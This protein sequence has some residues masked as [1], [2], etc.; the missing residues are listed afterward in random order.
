MVGGGTGPGGP[1]TKEG[2]ASGGQVVLPRL[3]E[4]VEKAGPVSAEV[5]LDLIRHFIREEEAKLVGQAKAGGSGLELAHRRAGLL[6]GVVVHLW[7]H[8][9]DQESKSRLVLGAVGGF[10]REE[11]SPASDVDLV[12]I[13]DGRKEKTEEEVVRQIL[14]VL[15]DIGL[16]VGHACRTVAETIERA[17]SEP[18]IKTALLD[19]R[20]L[21]GSPSLWQQFDSEFL[22]K[23]LSRGV[24]HY[25]SWRLENQAARHA[26]E[27]GTIYVQEPNLKTGVGGLRDFHNLRWVGKVSGQG[28]TLTGLAAQ[29]WLGTEEAVL[30]EKAFAFLM[31]VR[32]WLH[33]L[34]GGPGDVM[35]LRL[36]GELAVAMG[37]PQPN[38]LRQSEAL[39]REVYGHMR[40]IHLICNPAS[41]RICQQITGKPRGIWSFFSGWQGSRRATDG[42]VL[43]GAELQAEN[44]QV[45]TQDP[46][47]LIRVFRI[48]QDQG[49]IPSAQLVALLRANFGLLTEEL[50]GRREVQEVFLH[51]LK[52]KGKVARILRLM[53]ENGVLGRM[54]PEFAPLTCLVQHEFFHRYTADE[55]TL[56]CLEQLD[57]ML[58]SK[59]PDLR[60]Y[61]ELYARVEAPEILV[62]AM[63]LHDT[64]KA[65]LSRHHEEVGAANAARVARRFHFWGRNLSLMTFLVDHH[66][67]LGNFARQNLDEPETIRTFAR[68]V[69][70][71]E[72]LDLLMLLSAADVRAVAGRN[73]WSSWRELLVWDLYSRTRRMLAGEEEFLRAEEEERAGRTR[74]VA[75]VLKGSFSEQ[76][77]LN[78]LERMGPSY[79]RQCTAELVSRHI[80]A[81]HDFLERRVAGP[82][83]LVPLVVWQDYSEEGHTEVIVVTW[84]REKLFSKIAGSF[85]VA[86]INIL[87]AN[88]FTRSDDVV[89]DTFRVCTDRL[90]PVSHRIDRELFEKT[91]TEALGATEDHL[92]ERLAGQGPTMWQKA[93]GEAEFPASLRMDTESEP[94]RTLVHVQAPDRVGLLHA[95]TRAMSEEGFQIEGARITTEKGAAIDTFSILDSEGR[96]VTALA[97]L[98]RLLARLKGVV[99]R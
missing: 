67:T 39:M 86:G 1:A 18:M 94:G 11:M 31:T 85:A 72:R 2:S 27:G 45:F 58:D 74:Q 78:H 42:F 33:D 16:K 17:E 53:H 47:R 4:L 87:S 8:A 43:Q 26:K 41:T 81:V 44:A 55:H 92:A 69:Q 15:W 36:Q 80:R 99:S 3:E 83:A 51:I 76:E 77:M 28:D 84:N 64:G 30:A 7:N 61:A 49:S 91:L 22:K 12:F 23:S 52:Q 71:E 50:L 57:A 56:V 5:R 10:G 73:N 79:L 93:I 75:A 38:I 66:M 25:L 6:S 32:E 88:I 20:C 98:D 89:V 63:L 21:V 35:T 68:I 29:G 48:L 90:E 62:L 54:I 70:D 14:Y 13:R 96:P 65:E 24:E 40:S 37:Y 34:Q 82:E 60:K 46:S 9:G 19:A 95:L 59:D 97:N